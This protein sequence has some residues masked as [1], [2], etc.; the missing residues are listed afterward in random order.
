MGL[1]LSYLSNSHKERYY[2]M[3]SMSIKKITMGLAIIIANLIVLCYVMPEGKQNIKLQYKVKANQDTKYQVFYCEEGEFGEYVIDQDYSHINQ[4]TTLTYTLPKTVQHIRL[5]LGEK[6]AHIE[7]SEVELKYYNQK[8]DITPLI[9]ISNIQEMHD[10]VD[11]KEENNI[12]SMRATGID[13]FITIHLNNRQ[14]DMIKKGDRF[15]VGISKAI[16]LLILNLIA[17]VIYKKQEIIKNLSSEIYRNRSLIWSLSKNDFKTKYAG[18]YLGITW[19]FIQPIVTVL[20][21][22]FVFQVG[23]R[24][25][26]VGDFP[27]V[28]W[29]VTGI[30][31]WFCFSDALTN[32][33]NSMME[34]SYLVKKVVFKISILPI[35][36]IISALFVHIFFIVFTL[37]LFGC[38]GY[39]PN[40]YM[41]Q[42]IYYTI[43]MSLFVLAISYAT[44]AIVIFFRD[45]GQII[46]I[47]LQVGMWMTPIMWSHEM[48]PSQ[49]QWIL[50]LN[51]MYYI[52]EGYRDSLIYHVGFWHRFNQTIYFWIVTLGLFMMG[53]IIFKRLKVHFA[54]V[55]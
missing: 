40:I 45:L 2:M 23:F 6:P 53:T 52:V 55:L 42:I 22:W 24:S 54:D 10:I 48:I 19:A 7:I 34:Y 3:K 28:L 50:K 30:I 16:C 31:P 1:N 35:V 20:V 13:P 18:S 49:Y 41:L 21:Y 39:K 33:T 11:L 4:E 25:G 44:C 32:A 27:F 36:K 46:N 15:I 12:Y 29:L 26:D 51:P 9:G 5:D 47:V 17:V 8:L 14:A 37:I 38:Y 43:C